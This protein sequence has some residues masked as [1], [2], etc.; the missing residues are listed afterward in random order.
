MKKFAIIGTHGTGKTT[1][2]YEVTAE[3][4]KIGLHAE[5]LSEVA[6]RCPFP[7]HQA[8]NV[9]AQMWILTN[10]IAK[11]LDMERLCDYLI[12]D[13]NVIDYYVYLMYGNFPKEADM[14]KPLI[15]YHLKSYD[16][17]FTTKF[18]QKYLIPDGIRDTDP[19]FQKR[20]EEI[21]RKFLKEHDI[22]HVELPEEKGAT[23]IIQNIIDKRENLKK[24]L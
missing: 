23:V 4:K 6:R 3:L 10:Q 18:S 16:M 5:M 15:L 9:K 2:A 12:L 24:Y 21:L 7:I 22:K 17:I 8:V 11:E 20:I 1:L 14:L 13:R 19:A